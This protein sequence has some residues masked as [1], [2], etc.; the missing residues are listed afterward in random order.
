L[1]GAWQKVLRD[2]FGVKNC[3][4]YEG[5][6]GLPSDAGR[7][8]GI[9][10]HSKASVHCST[11]TVTACALPPLSLIGRRCSG[12]HRGAMHRARA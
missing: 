7:R 10:V 8:K 5:A 9:L 1:A 11:G 12:A 3:M 6:T 2:K 4:P